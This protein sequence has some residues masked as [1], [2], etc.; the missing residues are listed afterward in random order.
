MH[1]GARAPFSI[2]IILPGEA[3]PFTRVDTLFFSVPVVQRSRRQATAV[4]GGPPLDHRWS[5]YS[6]MRLEMA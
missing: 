1:V 5:R 3:G 4:F 2:Y 6:I